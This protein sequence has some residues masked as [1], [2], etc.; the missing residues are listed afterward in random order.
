MNKFSVLICLI[1]VLSACSNYSYLPQVDKAHRNIYGARIHITTNNLKFINGELLAVQR[2]SVYVLNYQ[3]E[4]ESVSQNSI[5]SYRLKFA[6]K[7]NKIAGLGATMVLV[8]LHGVFALITLPLNLFATVP[9][10]MANNKERILE[11]YENQS[12]LKAF[13][14]FPQG[15]PANYDPSF[16]KYPN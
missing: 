1:L 14:R 13:A 10:L 11:S 2:D 8:P 7:N 15:I 12:E 4:I 16:D 9:T 6:N 5:S 3:Y